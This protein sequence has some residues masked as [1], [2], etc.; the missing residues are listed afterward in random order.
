[1]S[2]TH[3]QPCLGGEY[4]TGTAIRCYDDDDDDGGDDDDDDDDDDAEGEREEEEDYED[5]DDLNSDDDGDGDGGDGDGGDDHD[6]DDDIQRSRWIERQ[7]GLPSWTKRPGCKQ[8]CTV[9]TVVVCTDNGGW[10]RLLVLLLGDHHCS[11][12][13]DCSRSVWFVGRR[14][15]STRATATSG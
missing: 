7:R 15:Q 8:R 14:A 11:S 2:S 3:I 9:L 13:Y 4:T 1:L 6:D 10:V 5:H 12:R